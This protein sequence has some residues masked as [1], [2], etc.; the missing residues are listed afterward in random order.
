MVETDKTMSKVII[1]IPKED[2]EFFKNSN[3]DCMVHDASRE[4]ALIE[5]VKNGVCISLYIK[6]DGRIFEEDHYSWFR[7]KCS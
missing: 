5:A 1:E 2:F 3:V 7:N 4:M 6:R